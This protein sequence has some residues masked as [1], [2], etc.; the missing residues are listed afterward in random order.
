MKMA[1]HRAKQ[2]EICASGVTIRCI[3]GISTVIVCK[4]ILGSFGA[5][6]IFDNFVSQK[7]QVLERTVHLNLCYPI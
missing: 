5:V 4:V 2:N 1:S 6:P 3:Q 7:R